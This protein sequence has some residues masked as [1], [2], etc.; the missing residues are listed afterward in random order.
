[1]PKFLRN[2]RKMLYDNIRKVGTMSK[3][4]LAFEITKIYFSNH[5]PDE[6][7]LVFAE[8]FMRYYQKV[9]NSII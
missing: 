7:I 4:T 1:M 6:D 3:E 5:F 9:L 2:N 8:K